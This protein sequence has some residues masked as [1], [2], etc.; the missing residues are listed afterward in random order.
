MLYDGV[1]LRA[2]EKNCGGSSYPLP[3]G[4]TS[5][6]TAT[7]STNMATANT[8]WTGQQPMALR[9]PQN[10][11]NSWNFKV[12]WSAQIGMIVVYSVVSSWDIHEL[13]SNPSSAAEYGIPLVAVAIF[14]GSI[15]A[16]ELGHAIT[17]ERLGIRVQTIGLEIWG[18]YTL[19]ADGVSLFNLPTRKYFWST[20]AGPATNLL[21]A[22]VLWRFVLDAPGV[23]ES[24]QILRDPDDLIRFFTA[25]AALI[26]AYLGVFN[27]LP[28]FP[29]DGGHV[30]RAVLM[31]MTGGV[32]LA[33]IIAGGVSLTLAGAG[34]AYGINETL[35]DGWSA[36]ADT[37]P[38]LLY[39]GIAVFGSIAALA[40]L[41]TRKEEL[42]NVVPSETD[43][44]IPNEIPSSNGSSSR[45]WLWW[46]VGIAVAIGVL[47]AL[48]SSSEDETRGSSQ[49][50]ATATAV[51]AFGTVGI[52]DLRDGDC[53]NGGFRGSET[54]T[55]ET[56]DRVSCDGPWQHQIV[57]SVLLGHAEG[58]PYPS[59]SFIQDFA[60]D[61]CPP[62]TTRF[63]YP[64]P[65]G[66]DLGDRVMRC[67]SQN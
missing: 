34:I 63:L 52:A 27:L 40:S 5:C 19:P 22:F 65:Q 38:L 51:P 46:I 11:G 28:V 7:A 26:N 62:M 66:W 17:M 54:V 4:Q 35:D 21:I 12:G 20:F 37:G 29:L 18:G 24:R 8:Y 3:G 60:E 67:I 45:S 55:I 36:V 1:R 13:L 25:W 61:N 56:V 14:F 39:S 53:F 43:G 44:R 58:V 47:A 49:V 32:T 16:H 33:T 10:A 9:H 15:L 42:G 48:D 6:L 30:L 57:R 41:F 31:A 59:E 2:I 23:S 64:D 50:V